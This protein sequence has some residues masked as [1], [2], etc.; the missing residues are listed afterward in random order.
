MAWEKVKPTEQDNQPILTK[1]NC[2]GQCPACGESAEGCEWQEVDF[3]DNDERHQSATCRK[4]GCL[5]TE[6]YRHVETQYQ[7]PIRALRMTCMIC[8]KKAIPA[9][10]SNQIDGKRYHG[11]K[12]LAGEEWVVCPHCYKQN[13]GTGDWNRNDG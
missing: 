1:K 11:L 2:A 10:T 12:E 6:I 4:C 8:G 7:E 9:G 5:F 13:D 3:C